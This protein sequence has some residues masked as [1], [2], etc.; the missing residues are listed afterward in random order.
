M[1]F[2]VPFVSFITFSVRF[3]TIFYARIL[4]DRDVPEEVRVDVLGGKS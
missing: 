3:E 2:F 1:V 4:V